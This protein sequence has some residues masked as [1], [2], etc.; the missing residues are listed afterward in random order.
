[1]SGEYL[2][3]TQDANGDVDIRLACSPEFA[4]TAVTGIAN[5]CQT[6]PSFKPD[7]HCN[8]CLAVQILLRAAAE[9]TA[10]S[11]EEGVTH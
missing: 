2:T 3:A 10:L 11:G 8:K 4:L 9:I 7:C 1:M 5:L 6:D